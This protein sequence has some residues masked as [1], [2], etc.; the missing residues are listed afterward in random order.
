M[1]LHEKLVIHENP[2]SGKKKGIPFESLGNFMRE[3][4]L[5]NINVQ[6]RIIGDELL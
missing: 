2:V 3:E 1:C 6:N 4:N 5:T